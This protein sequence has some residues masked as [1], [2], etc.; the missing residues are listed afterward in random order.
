MSALVRIEGHGPVAAALRLFL[1]R[2]GLDAAQIDAESAHQTLPD[3]LAHRALALS[4][5]SL[6]LLSGPVPALDPRRVASGETEAAAIES[7]EIIRAGALSRSLLQTPSG[8]PGCLGA[9]VRYGVLHR[10]LCAAG[11][12]MAHAPATSGALIRVLA[13][14][15]PRDPGLRD[16][17]QLAL[18]SEIVAHRAQ[19][20]R[21]WERFTSEGPLAL[22]PLPTAGRWSLVWCAPPEAAKRRQALAKPAFEAELLAAFGPALGPLEL[23]SPRH[24]TPLRR[25][26][27]RV[28]LDRLCVAIGN[29]SQSLHPVAGQGLNLGLRD[30]WVLA[31]CLGDTLAESRRRQVTHRAA[32]PQTRDPPDAAWVAALD[33]YERLRAPDRR[34]L[35]SLT[36]QLASLTRPE[37][38]RPVQSIAL[39][40]LELCAPLKRLAR[41][42]FTHGRRDL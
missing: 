29:A 27:G 25:Q 5:G 30:A 41:S 23:A 42:T 40:A 22:L 3:W 11:Q 33:R 35:L 28:R 6:E 15:E 2:E 14:G 1:M 34:L 18:T 37:G 32:D 9:V 13:D 36:D 16:F 39:A 24:L 4:V 7:V 8:G 12:G 38:L 17:D 21:A 10:L 19:P 31:R 20:A 26:E